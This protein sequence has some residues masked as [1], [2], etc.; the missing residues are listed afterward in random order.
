MLQRND[1]GSLPAFAF[2]GGY[3]IY[4][5]DG[6]NSVLCPDCANASDRDPKECPQF[7]P[8]TGEV[9]WEDAHL[10]CDNCN[11]RIE[12]AYAEDAAQ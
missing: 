9:N 11:T 12:S 5:L 1:D 8:V 3:P 6:E 2:P 10:H 4:Y 7:R